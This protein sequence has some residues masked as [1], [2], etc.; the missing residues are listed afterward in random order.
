MYDADAAAMDN[1]ELLTS[2]LVTNGVVHVGRKRPATELGLSLIR[3]GERLLAEVHDPSRDLPHARW[4]SSGSPDGA[5]SW[6]RT[7]TAS[8]WPRVQAKSCGSS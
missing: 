4:A 8:T 1:A 7:T 3:D 5:C 2:E 6:S